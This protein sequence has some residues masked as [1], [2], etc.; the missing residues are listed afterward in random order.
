MDIKEC[1]LAYFKVQEDD[2][3]TRKAFYVNAFYGVHK[4][5]HSLTIFSTYL[6]FMHHGGNLENKY[7]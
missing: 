7:H 6:S 5:Y 2:V 1:I 3:K 4:K